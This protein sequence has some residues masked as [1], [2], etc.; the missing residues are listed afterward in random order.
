MTTVPAAEL[1]PL[2]LTLTMPSLEQ[3][4]WL[5][6]IDQTVNPVAADSI[7]AINKADRLRVYIGSTKQY[8]GGLVALQVPVPLVN[9]LPPSK[10]AVTWGVMPSDDCVAQ[11]RCYELDAK[12]VWPPAPNATTQVQNVYDGSVQQN[13][14]ESGMWQVD[15]PTHTWQD[16]GFKTA[17]LVAGF[18]NYIEITYAF[19]FTAKVCS[20]ETIS[21]EAGA[22]MPPTVGTITTP[23]RVPAIESNWAM[24]VNNVPEPLLLL[25]IQ[26]D[27]NVAAAAYYCDYTCEVAWGL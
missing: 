8:G 27:V 5:P 25:Q 11:N 6:R 14:A 19:D 4:P 1:T 21:V 15:G 23:T 12:L 3:Q 13:L 22:A 24:Y 9:G 17:P 2:T 20:V 16:T 18:W 26:L 10:L 7:Q